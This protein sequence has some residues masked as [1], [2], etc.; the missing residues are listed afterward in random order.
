MRQVRPEERGVKSRS[1][2]MSAA[3]RELIR[4]AVVGRGIRPIDVSRLLR[5]ST[6]SVAEHLAAIRRDEGV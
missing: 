1:S 4:L 3:R 6:A 5:I 2:A